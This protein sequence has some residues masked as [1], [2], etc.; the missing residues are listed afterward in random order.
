MALGPPQTVA[1]GLERGR[2]GPQPSATVRSHWSSLAWVGSLDPES[3]TEDFKRSWSYPGITGLTL[4]SPGDA[5][6]LTSN[7]KTE[8]HSREAG[9]PLKL[10]GRRHEPEK[11]NMSSVSSGLNYAH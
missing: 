1:A 9:L 7:Q 11:D 10:G 5:P 4:I 6:F 3:Q 2:E 8:V